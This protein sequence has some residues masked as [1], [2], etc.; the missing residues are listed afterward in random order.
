VHRP[1]ILLQAVTMAVA[2]SAP[3]QGHAEDLLETYAQARHSDPVLSSADANRQV[4]GE[5]V[6]QA[7]AGL[8]PQL[9]AGFGVSD[10]HVSGSP[11]LD[12]GSG[13]RYRQ[14]DVSAN[15]TQVVVDVGRIARLD[16]AHSLLDAQDAIYRNAEQDLLIRVASAYFDVLLAQDNLITVQANEDAYRQ[17][18]D[19]A[20]TR[21]G[22]GLSAQVDVEQGRS[23][24]AAAR[25]SSISARKAVEDARDALTQVTGIEPG[26]LKVLRDSLP[27]NPPSPADPKAWVDVALAANPVLLAGKR[28]IEAADSSIDAARAGHLPTLSAGVQ[29]GRSASWPLVLNSF[30]SRTVTSVGLTLTVPLFAGGAIQ[31]QVRQAVAQREGARDDLETQRRSVMRNTLERYRRVVLGI[32]QTQV[33]EQS[34][35]SAQKALDSTRVGLGLGTQT[36]TDLL[37]AIRNLASAQLDYSQARHQFVL[38]RLLLLQAAGTITEADL[39]AVNALLH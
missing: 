27:M 36:M 15:L 5:D 32:E 29:V 1:R 17:L 3:L 22:N 13:N 14:R 39:V 12:D 16:A 10:N 26:K 7:R 9:S 37:L 38:G 18:V 28:Q 30:D 35:Q 11:V 21:Y 34:V 25:T 20:T 4:V 33:S 6:V 2:L 31:S 19:Q 23:Y 24:L 8:L